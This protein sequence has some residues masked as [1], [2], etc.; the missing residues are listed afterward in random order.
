[1]SVADEIKARIDIVDYIQRY[2]PLKRAGRTYKACCPWHQE[3]TPSFSVDPDRQSYRCFG[4]CAT[5]GDV[6]GFAMRHHGWSFGEALQELGK[7]AGVEVERQ[8]PEQRQNSERLDKLRGLMHTAADVYHNSLLDETVEGQPDV[9]RYTREK[10][11]FN[12]TTITAYKI[13]FAPAGW[14]NMLDH[15]KTL[16]YTESEIIEV[17]LA[18]KN[19]ETG[20]VYDRFRNRLMIPI[21]DERGRVIAFGARALAAEDNPKYLN[22]PQ[23]PL[24]DKSRTLFG[25][26]AAKASIRE[27][28]EAVI[29]EGYMDAIQAHQAGFKNVVAQMGTAMTE[30]QLRLLTRSAKK[31]ILAL[32]SDAAGQNATR[33]SL[34]TA[35]TTLQADFGGRLSVDIRV[36]QI[37]DAKDPDDLI[38]ETPERWAE[39]VAN[40]LPVA[41]FVIDMEA[42]S[43]PANASVMEREAVAR[44]VLPLLVASENNLYKRDNIQKLALRLHIAE[45]DLLAWADEQTRIEKAK[46]PRTPPPAEKKPHPNPPRK[47]GGNNEV[48]TA[49]YGEP[50]DVPPM[51]YEVL[52]PPPD[53]GIDDEQ[54]LPDEVAF[55][56]RPASPEPSISY[57]AAIARPAA[58]RV[59]PIEETM[60]EVV[61]LRGLFRQ[62]MAYYMVNRKLRE[63]A[64]DDRTMIDGPLSDCCADDFTHVD[65]RALMQAFQASLEQDELD[66]LDYLRLQAD[67][68]LQPQLDVILADDITGMRKRVRESHTADLERI[69]SH[70]RRVLEGADSTD[71]IVNQALEL[72]ARRVKREREELVF[73]QMDAQANDDE[74]AMMRYGQLIFLFN[75]AQQLLDKNLQK[76]KSSVRE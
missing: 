14:T 21:R 2:V 45:R 26:D 28:E 61:V 5:G 19:E 24:F 3:K 42:A 27:S 63:L 30:T 41:D 58:R 4:A 13:G 74:D 48:S 17:G 53:A 23:T 59:A 40:A 25:L 65:A 32:D 18:V 1:M 76:F 49:D 9:L 37:P 20:R 47:Q 75:K 67:I 36:L 29:V 7:L 51:D 10:R 52:G 44:N 71:V 50:P 46:K 12:N 16:G 69:Y 38:R 6:I 56:K 55:V 57:A 68:S 35:R 60:I 70:N 64:N 54:L 8:T 62:P 34:E 31:I 72:R 22:S 73:L 15:L 66:P 33:R 43:L 39:L 11:G